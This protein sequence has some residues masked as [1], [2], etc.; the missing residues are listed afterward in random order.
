MEDDGGPGHGAERQ[1]RPG[2]RSDGQGRRSPR[3]GQARQ[4]RRRA[5]L[6]PR[7]ASPGRA[8]PRPADGERPGRSRRRHAQRR[9]QFARTT[10]RSAGRSVRTAPTSDRPSRFP[11]RSIPSAPARS[12]TRFGSVSAR[13]CGPSSSASTSSACSTA[14][15][16]LVLDYTDVTAVRGR[17]A[18]H[19]CRSRRRK[20][21]ARRNRHV[22]P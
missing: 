12:S 14:S 19:P 2:R 5:G 8:G 6:G 17:H 18:P 1:A 13:P 20:D 16:R 11:T 21:Q 4:R 7:R 9:R 3:Q 15:D 22:R 10:I